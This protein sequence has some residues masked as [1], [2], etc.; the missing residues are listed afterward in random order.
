MPWPGNAA[1]PWISTGS[2]TLR[3]KVGAPGLSAFV[4][5]ARAMPS[6]TGFTASRWLGFGTIDTEMWPRDFPCTST[7]APA[8]YFTSPVKPRSMRHV[9]ESTGSLNSA[10]ICAY[11]FCRMCARTLSRPRCAIPISMSAMPES[12]A[13][14]TIS[15]RMGRSMSRPST[16]K[17]VLPGNVRC[18]KRSKTSTCVSRSSSAS[19]STVVTGGRKRPD[20]A[21]S[22]SHSRSSGTN[23]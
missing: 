20:S 3:S 6:T 19:A 1:S 13:P 14:A 17:R 7:V 8:W 16:E 10:R 21:A 15:S 22:R 5:A 12:V 23:T 4:P 18:R 9:R 2:V 11:G